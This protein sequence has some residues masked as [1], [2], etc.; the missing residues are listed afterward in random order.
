MKLSIITINYNNLGGLRK[1]IDSVLSQIWKNYE[2]II[3]DGGS[4]DGS[5]ELIE[6]TY[7]Q[8]SQSEFNPISFWCSEQ[9]GGI[10]N[11]INKGIKHCGGEYINCMNSGDE[12]YASDVLQK[13]FQETLIGDIV[14]GDWYSVYSDRRE[15]N[16][17]LRE[18]LWMVFYYRNICHQAIFCKA[19]ILKEKGFREDMLLADWIRWTEEL[20]NYAKFQRVPYVI[21]NY[22]MDGVSS[23]VSE[24][25]FIREH[26]EVLT[27][28]AGF[29]S[30]CNSDYYVYHAV[31][32]LRTNP[33]L[34]IPLKFVI[35]V[36]TKIA[37]VANKV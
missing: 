21:C 29:I 30:S 31:R 13:V 26:R 1:T 10:Y 36:L 4:T 8:L 27:K 35:S 2:W 23:Q 34:R 17:I 32:I 7:Q 16:C 9:D 14:Y 33:K 19:S 6:S 28:Y 11:A 15:L 5:K 22:Y 25:N 12:F 37:K 18:H 20:I 3:I 24:S